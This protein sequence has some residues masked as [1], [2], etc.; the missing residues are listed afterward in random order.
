M[1]GI[2]WSALYFIFSLLPIF[3]QAQTINAVPEDPI[4]VSQDFLYVARTGDTTA[5]GI[6]ALKNLNQ[7]KLV[8]A[9][10]TD[11]ARI[12]FWVNIYNGFT[13]V[14]LSKNPDQYK[15]KGVF[16]ASRQIE[17]AGK[18]MS[19]DFIEHGIL[20]HSK[21]KWAEGYIGKLFPSA[22][23]KK[24][25]V[26]RL[27]YRIHFAL[28]CGAKSCPPIAFYKPEKLSS[29]LNIATKTYLK[30]ECEYDKNANTVTVPAL[31]GWFRGDF[32]GKSG[33]RTILAK[34]GIIPEEA[35]PK[36]KFKSYD[37]TLY[38]NNYK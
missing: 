11:E 15:S 24:Y 25:R 27:D 5:N 2:Y 35:E 12:A 9:L 7:D 21:I 1:K 16:F 14:M 8:A 33:I 30:G 31:M 10:N 29:Q 18:L 26:N 37:W 22:L 36:I 34:N 38:L 3:M 19:L 6:A 20:R 4:K 28:N 13:Q 17:I 32:G 23:E